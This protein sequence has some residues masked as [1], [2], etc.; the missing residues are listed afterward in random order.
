MKKAVSIFR[1]ILIFELLFFGCT[2]VD[3]QTIITST[4]PDTGSHSTDTS[5]RLKPPLTDSIPDSV[6]IYVYEDQTNAPLDSVFYY[7]LYCNSWTT[8]NIA[9]CSNDPNDPTNRKFGGWYS[10]VNGHIAIRRP[11]TAG[12]PPPGISPISVFTKKNYFIR[13]GYDS[14]TTQDSIETAK[15]WLF[16]S[17]WLKLHLQCDKYSSGIITVSAEQNYRLFFNAFHAEVNATIDTTFIITMAAN[18]PIGV[19][20]EV[21]TIPGGAHGDQRGLFSDS[22]RISKFDT[23]D[24]EVLVH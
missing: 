24:M 21:D 22:P 14:L 3:K 20:I 6:Y 19:F 8:Y 18:Y 16:P 7:L 23:L 10:D 12:N 2:K 15:V 17:A 11:D 5:N 9:G 4:R 13:W 1:A